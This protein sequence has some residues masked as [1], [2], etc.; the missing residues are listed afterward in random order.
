MERKV[1]F[2]YPP[3]SPEISV[4]TWEPLQFVFLTRSLREGG[5]KVELLDGRFVREKEKRLAFV[6][7]TAPF[8]ICVTSLTC[9]QYLDALEFVKGVK[10][11]F[12]GIP[13][14]LGGWHPTIFPKDVLEETGAEAVVLG[15]GEVTLLNVLHRLWEDK[16]LEGLKGVFWKKGKDKIVFEGE[17]EPVHPNELPKVAP[18]DFKSLGLVPPR[19][20]I[21]HQLYYMSSVGCPYRCYY[22][23]VGSFSGKWMGEGAERVVKVIGG[24]KKNFGFKKVVFWDNVFFVD[25]ERALEIAHGLSAMGLEWSTHARVNEVVKWEID[26][27]N[28]LKEYG[29]EELFLG[30]ESGSQRVLDALNKKI[31]EKDIL[32]AIKRLISTGIKVTTNW[33]F[34]IP[35]EKY[36][37]VV[38]SA[39]LI[40]RGFKAGKGFKVFMYRF[41]PLPGTRIYEALPKDE[42]EKLPKKSKDWARYIHEAAA[43][44]MYPWRDELTDSY[45]APATFYIWKGYLDEK[46]PFLIKTLSRARIKLGLFKLPFEWIHW[47]KSRM[48]QL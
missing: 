25:K 12:P 32:P 7:K 35:G 38:K 28:K 47:K 33:M 9:Y 44:G 1:L 36:K 30:A 17:A 43:D 22:C 39:K 45:F 31:S 29:C 46:A 19:Y 8:C 10:E 20:Q 11:S 23:S 3:V 5:F 13:I 15:Q 26:Y 24:L 34:G 6:K 41:V 4:P 2:Y 16:G 40:A 21:S 14:V 48:R 18:E 37:D 42:K 27:L